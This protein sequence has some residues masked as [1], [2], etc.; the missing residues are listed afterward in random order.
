M[1]WCGC[2]RRALKVANTLLANDRD[3]FVTRLSRVREISHRFGY[4]V[5]DDMDFLLSKC[6]RRSD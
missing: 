6:T 4:G 3:D 5:G 2:S 1:H